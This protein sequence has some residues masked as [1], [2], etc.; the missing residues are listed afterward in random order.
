MIKGLG[1]DVKK[2]GN[3]LVLAPMTDKQIRGF[4]AG[5]IKNSKVVRGKD[6][7]PEK[8]GLFDPLITGG[9]SGD[10]WNHIELAEEL[11][12]PIF[13]NAIKS[14]LGMTQSI[15]DDIIAG[16]RY[17][18]KDGKILTEETDDSVTGG[19]GIKVLLSKID[20]DKK[21]ASLHSQQVGDASEAGHNAASYA[22]RS[23]RVEGVVVE[24]SSAIEL[25]SFNLNVVC[26]LIGRMVHL[27]NICYF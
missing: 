6:L 15:Y 19:P 22:G 12:N 4:S 7:R 9:I 11:P 13:E 14:L 3:Q 25:R 17:V 8:G 1:V 26:I 24:Y 18:S 20:V 10:K 23:A 27:L 5:A 21:I 16:R 2:D